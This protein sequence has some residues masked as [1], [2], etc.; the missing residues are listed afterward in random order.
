MNKENNSILAQS[1]IAIM[2]TPITYRG[3]IYDPYTGLYYLQSRYY[4]PTYGRFLNA[5]TTEILEATQ[6]T[7]LGANLFAYC[8]NNPVN[9]VD[10]MGNIALSTIIVGILLFIV[11]VVIFCAFAY[12]KW[13]SSIFY[14]IYEMYDKTKNYFAPFYEHAKNVVE[15]GTKVNL[16]PE[17]PDYYKLGISKPYSEVCRDAYNTAIDFGYIK[18]N[19]CWDSEENVNL[20]QFEEM[21]DEQKF[22]FTAA[23]IVYDRTTYYKILLVYMVDLIGWGVGTVIGS[24]TPSK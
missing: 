23:M 19:Q 18:S 6:G 17:Y 21:D 10:P 16:N 9:M 2:Y 14:T 8:N 4:N 11:A 5:D 7:P 24:A 3:Y 12:L 20:Q 1:L 13:K 15:Y 22:T